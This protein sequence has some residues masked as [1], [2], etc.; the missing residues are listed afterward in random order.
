MNERFP[1]PQSASGWQAVR[2]VAADELR[3]AARSRW[4]LVFAITF[5]ALALGISYFG[6]AGADTAGFQSFERVTASLLNLVLLWVPLV[7]LLIAVARLTGSRESLGFFL[8]QPLRRGDALIGKYLGLTVAFGL[9]QAVGFGGAG[10]V[11]AFAAG[12]ANAG[13]YFALVA[14]S[15][16]LSAIFLALGV[17]IATLSPDRVRS[18]GAALAVWLAVTILYDLAAVGLTSVVYGLPVRRM[19]V[20]AVWLN[21]VDLS[22][23]LATAAMGSKSLFGP[24]GAAVGALSRK[25]SRERPLSLEFA[26]LAHYPARLCG[27]PLRGEGLIRRRPNHG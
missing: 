24:T 7:S 10:L 17:L 22:R 12:S 3:R 27:S 1:L 25:S 15:I 2:I 14:L 19:L 21:P 11:V 26:S 9:A 5:S 16:A 13:G 23:V 20:T 18:L 4:I 6:L 8:A